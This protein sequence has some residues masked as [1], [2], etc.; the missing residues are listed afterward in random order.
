MNSGHTTTGHHGGPGA[1]NP[2]QE[3]KDRG[4]AASLFASLG[5]LAVAPRR[6]FE[7]TRGDAGIWSPL[8]FT[9]LVSTL[10]VLLNQLVLTVLTVTVSEPARDLVHRA[11]I[12]SGPFRITEGLDQ[13]SFGDALQ[14]LASL[15]A[16]LLVL[17]AIFVLT[18]IVTL[19]SS[20]FTHVFL[21]LTRTPRAHGFRGTWAVACYANG[22]AMLGAVPVA[23]DFLSVICT[24]ALFAV[25]LHVVQGI[26]ALRATLFATILP[27]LL[28]SSLLLP[29]G[30]G[31]LGV[32]V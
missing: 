10:A 5:L 15:Q 32:P 29:W 6:F 12:W 21:L 22:A 20:A 24:T 9:G 13:T 8:L 2:W 14:A 18:L 4:L 27:L 11:E 23:G 26:G 30:F 7:D 3:R 16:L 1:S 25:G 17:P 19:F 28:F 31:V